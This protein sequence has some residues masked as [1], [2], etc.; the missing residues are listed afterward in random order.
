M[1]THAL[2]NWRVSQ[3]LTQQ[4]VAQMAD[5]TRATICRIELRVEDPSFHL[6]KRLVRASAG[7]VTANDFLPPDLLPAAQLEAAQ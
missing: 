5:T 4:D 7:A 3:G 2:R 1:T 6:I